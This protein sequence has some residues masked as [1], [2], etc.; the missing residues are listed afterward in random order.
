MLQLYGT[1]NCGVFEID[2]LSS[3]KDPQSAFLSAMFHILRVPVDFPFVTFTGVVKFAY[4]KES[5]LHARPRDDDYGEAFAQY[6]LENKLGE[7]VRS[8]VRKNWSDNDIQLWVW[9]IDRPAAYALYD[10]LLAE[11][12]LTLRHAPRVT[13][14]ISDDINVD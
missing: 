1:K 8:G 7:I 3:E 9:L 5:R 6:I 2:L 4:T 10:K 13:E 12:G 14:R 11:R